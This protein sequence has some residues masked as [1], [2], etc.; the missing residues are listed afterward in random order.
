MK[1][2]CLA[3]IALFSAVTSSAAAAAEF[4]QKPTVMGSKVSTVTTFRARDRNSRSF[5]Q[6]S[7]MCFSDHVTRHW[8]CEVPTDDTIVHCHLSCRPP[9]GDC[10][11]E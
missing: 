3:A 10:I 11:F 2:A 7:G 1:I 6:C 4:T 5:I 8:Q 9:H